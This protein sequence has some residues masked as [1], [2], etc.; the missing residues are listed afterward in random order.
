MSSMRVE[1]PSFL[2]TDHSYWLDTEFNRHGSLHSPRWQSHIY[3]TPLWRQPLSLE[4]GWMNISV[5]CPPLCIPVC[6][7]I[8]P[9]CWMAGPIK[10]QTLLSSSWYLLPSLTVLPDPNTWVLVGYLRVRTEGQCCYTFYACFWKYPELFFETWLWD[11]WFCS[12]EMTESSMELEPY[13]MLHIKTEQSLWVRLIH[14]MLVSLP[15]PK[16]HLW[17]PICPVGASLGWS[18]L[19]TYIMQCLELDVHQ[20]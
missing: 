5:G 15:T 3:L 18:S 12:K 9:Q 14:S 1:T 2:L 20:V 8:L 17:L 10:T 16:Q 6:Q 19:L 13:I 4:P 7:R 11:Y